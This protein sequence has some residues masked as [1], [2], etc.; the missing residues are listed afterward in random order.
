[1]SSCSFWGDPHFSQSFFAGPKIDYTE[2][3]EYEAKKFDFHGLGAYEL[4]SSKDGSFQVQ[5][6][7]V[8][9]RGSQTMVNV[10][11]ALKIDG[12]IIFISKDEILGDISDL[13]PVGDIEDKED[14]LT[15][16]SSDCRF[17]FNVQVLY[18]GKH[19]PGFYHN[20][21]VQMNDDLFASEGICGKEG[22]NSLVASDG[23]LFTQDQ[24][25]DLCSLATGPTPAHCQGSRVDLVQTNIGVPGL[26]YTVTPEAACK[27]K[28]C[29]LQDAQVACSATGGT[30]FHDGCVI[31]YCITECD[32]IMVENAIAQMTK[33]QEQLSGGDDDDDDV[34]DPMSG[35]GSKADEQGDRQEAKQK[36]KEAKM[37]AKAEA[38]SGKGDVQGDPMDTPVTKIGKGD[39]Q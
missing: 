32:P 10:G 28:T 35:K 39:G 14:G 25:S 38:K 36:K 24:L 37:K 9:F 26:V 7:Q 19:S 15:F 22:Y 13:S 29:T 31:D 4:A 23:L 27:D 2:G 20:A 21:Q 12:K 16:Q 3:S 17:R 5:V 30:A 8:P 18:S 34:I 33:L 11:F 6:F 1:M